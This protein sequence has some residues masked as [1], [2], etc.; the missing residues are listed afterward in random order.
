MRPVGASDPHDLSWKDL[1][2]SWKSCEDQEEKQLWRGPSEGAVSRSWR[3]TRK[4]EMLVRVWAA[5]ST[6]RGQS[7]AL[8]VG[9]W[10]GW[11]WKSLEMSSQGVMAT[12]GVWVTRV[13]SGGISCGVYEP[14]DDVISW[15]G[16][17]T[18]RSATEELKRPGNENFLMRSEGLPHGSVLRE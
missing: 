18:N 2:G 10:G 11:G 4:D 1:K 5:A 16:E 14:S 8:D 15:Y 3:E 17:V 9:G 12:G 7:S 13:D 6:R